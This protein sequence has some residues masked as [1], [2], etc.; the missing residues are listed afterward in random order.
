MDFEYK[1]IRSKRKTIALTISKSCEVIVRAPNRTSKKYIEDFVA[2]H[3]LWIEKNLQEQQEKLS[4]IKALSQEKIENLKN[5][6]KESLPKRVDYYSEII[7]VKPTSVKITSAKTRFGSCSGKNGICFS[8]YLMQYDK[9]AID[10]VV[11]H[12]LCHIKH[13]NHSKQF[14]AL[15]E[16]YMPD[17]K[18]QI[19]KLKQQ[20]E[21]CKQTHK[22]NNTP[23]L[24]IQNAQQVIDNQNGIITI[25]K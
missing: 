8:L 23:V 20:I 4:N 2:K 10:Y 15:V 22:Q 5:M 11:V 13:H 17:Y 3:K 18:E 6:A 12:E 19:K 9:A 25:K 24:T 16:K 21:H 14:W 1:I 7:G